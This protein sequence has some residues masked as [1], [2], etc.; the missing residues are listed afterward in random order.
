MMKQTFKVENQEVGK[1]PRVPFL[2]AYP[3]VIQMVMQVEKPAKQC[4]L[5]L[6]PILE[7]RHRQGQEAR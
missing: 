7:F 6:N 3:D 1:V 4:A 2:M 5:F